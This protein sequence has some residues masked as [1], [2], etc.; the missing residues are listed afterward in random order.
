M[1]SEFLGTHKVWEWTSEGGLSALSWKAKDVLSSTDTAPGTNMGPM[2]PN[3]L[4]IFPHMPLLA[5]SIPTPNGGK[6]KW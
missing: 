3:Q 1:G 2:A 6:L 4:S 5:A